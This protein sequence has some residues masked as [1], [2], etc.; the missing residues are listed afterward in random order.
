MG[1]TTM[2]KPGITK[3]QGY[4]AGVFCVVYDLQGAINAYGI[5]MCHGLLDEIVAGRIKTQYDL[6]CWYEKLDTSLQ[7]KFQR[8]F[9]GRPRYRIAAKSRKAA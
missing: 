8:K 5:K 7:N 1:H 9:E 6:Q 3:A 2:A 4:L